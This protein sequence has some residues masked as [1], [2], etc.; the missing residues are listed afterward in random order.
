MDRTKKSQSSLFR[1]PVRTLSAEEAKR[2]VGGGAQSIARKPS[3][4]L[5]DVQGFR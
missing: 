1:T 4:I 5:T 2:V 3:S